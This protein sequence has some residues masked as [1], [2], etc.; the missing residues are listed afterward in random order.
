MELLYKEESFIIRGVAF[1]IYKQFRSNH[2]EKIYHNACFIGLTNKG[3]KAENDKRI[4]VFFCGKKVGVY[5]PDL[6]IN[7][8]ILIEL[9]AK[10][11]LL[12]EDEKQFWYY[13]KGTDYKLGFLI[14]FGA[15]DGVEIVRK[16]YDSARK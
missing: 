8:S 4:D 6:I 1:D 10:P 3:L 16:V 13:L 5:V 15:P 9:K 12:K 11:R 7:D 14:N 2:K